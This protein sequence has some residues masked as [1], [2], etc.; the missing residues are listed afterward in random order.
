MQAEQQYF[1]PILNSSMITIG[2]TS[3]LSSDQTTIREECNRINVGRVRLFA[4]VLLLVHSFLLYRDF[5]VLRVEGFWE[6]NIGYQHLCTMHIILV[7]AMLCFLLF[8]FKV[9]TL[10]ATQEHW[11]SLYNGA[12]AWCV[13]LWCAVLAGWVNQHEHGLI[14]EYVIA[15]FGIAS[16]FYFPPVQS[17]ILF[18]MAQIVFMVAVA[19]MLPEPNYSGHY[20]NTVAMIIIAWVLARTSFQLTVKNITNQKIIYDQT[21]ALG[22]RNDELMQKNARLE[23]LDHERTELM[24]IVAHDLKNPISAV[25]GLVEALHE[26]HLA[27][28][29]RTTILAQLMDVNDQMLELVKNLLDINHL[30]SGMMNLGTESFD[31]IPFVECILDRYTMAATAKNIT[32]HPPERSV[33]FFVYAS[34]QATMQILDNII[35]NAVKY[36]PH[37]KNVFVRVKS[38]NNTVRV[39][40]QDEGEGISPEDM[41]KLFGKFAR[42]TARPTGGEHSTGLGLS[43][44][45][46]MVEAMQ[47]RVWCESKLG[48]GA[49]FIVELPASSEV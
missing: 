16:A 39:E 42:L 26:E 37:G 35:S 10:P 44:V 9:Q 29:M 41:K 32:V 27:A 46:K 49:T 23:L 30:E 4:L 20:T 12:F 43:I 31:I 38:S 8:S 24:G 36:S 22:Q 1:F 18:L 13:L 3:S 5:A 45:K 11:R 25:R 40:V 17:L 47:G 28:P 33:S 15:I 48:K 2:R 14:T 7:V 19:I 6:R 21:V 34:E